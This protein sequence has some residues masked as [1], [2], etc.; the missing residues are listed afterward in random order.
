[1]PQTMTTL[2]LRDTP[3]TL[4]AIDRARVPGA[5]ELYL[6]S[7]RQWLA[8]I[9]HDVDRLLPVLS[10]AER[11]RAERFRQIIDRERYIVAHWLLR[12]VLARH[13]HIPSHT[14][15]FASGAHGK[16]WLTAPAGD[17]TTPLHFNLSHSGDLVLI[18]VGDA[19]LG[20]DIESIER[21]TDDDTWQALGAMLH[22]ADEW[23]ALR[24][25][26]PALLGR[27]VVQRWARHEARRKATGQGLGE[28]GAAH[29]RLDLTTDQHSWQV[30]DVQ[31]SIHPLDREPPGHAA[32]VAFDADRTRSLSGAWLVPDETGPGTMA[33]IMSGRP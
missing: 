28:T 20:V 31:T 7:C 14:L 5:V 23:A 25:S 2:P 4:A 3:L 19:P 32:A 15:S 16:P 11:A 13:L 12:E 21:E 29:G 6:V 1:M 8:T 9:D 24:D 26:P 33:R 30:A 10:A 27:H 17:A 22:T 18:G